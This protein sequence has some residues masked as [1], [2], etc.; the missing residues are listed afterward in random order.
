MIL[1][2]PNLNSNRGTAMNG[3]REWLLAENFLDAI[4]SANSK[5]TMGQGRDKEISGFCLHN[6]DIN[7]FARKNANQMFIV[8]AFVFYTIQKE[9]EIVRQTFPEYLKWL[10]ETAIHNDDWNYSN[11]PF[12]KFSN[13]LGASKK[14]APNKAVYLAELWS[15]KDEVYRNIMHWID[16]SYSSLSDNSDYQIFKYIREEIRG[17]GI[18]KS[19][20]AAQLILGKFGC[21]DSVNTRA[22]KNMI[23]ADIKKKGKKSGFT[24][25][26]R[27]GK[28]GIIK[29][30]G[31]KVKDPAVK[32]SLIGLKGYVDFLNT[33]QQLYGDN[34][35]KILWDD[36]CEIVGQK[37]VKSGTNEKINLNVNGQNFEINPYTQKS[38]LKDMMNKEKLHLAKIDPETTGTGVSQAHRDIILSGEK[39]GEN[40]DLHQF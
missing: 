8:F 10:F 12:K 20:F 34:I 11:Q 30:D 22:Y 26:T 25:V 4:K 32:N 1:F 24:M 5:I 39:Y 16:K 29:K 6:P 14:K 33:L 31:K 23:M 7:I 28:E 9:W 13:L 3:F 21:L 37:V 18:V 40:Y 36:W 19:A 35:S 2:G 27:K 38:N 15:K 17:L